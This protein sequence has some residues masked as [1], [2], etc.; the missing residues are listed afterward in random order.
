MGYIAVGILFF[1]LYLVFMAVLKVT[2]K[3]KGFMDWV[4][5]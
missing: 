1:S 2:K 5:K 4:N 3:E